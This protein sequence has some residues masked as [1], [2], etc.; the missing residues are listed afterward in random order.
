MNVSGQPATPASSI[1]VGAGGSVTINNIGG[2]RGSKRMKGKGR[3]SASNDSAVSNTRGT[4]R[5]DLNQR[6]SRASGS[7]GNV[8]G[9]GGCDGRSPAA[10][11]PLYGDGS[12]AA[13][14]TGNKGSDAMSAAAKPEFMTQLTKLAESIKSFISAFGSKNNQATESQAADATAPTS[15]LDLPEASK[16]TDAAANK[17]GCSGPSCATPANATPASTELETAT[18][19]SA[20]AKTDDSADADSSAVKEDNTLNFLGKLFM[21]FAS[22]LMGNKGAGA[23][24][25]GGALGS[26]FGGATRA[27][28]AV[29]TTTKTTVEEQPA[30]PA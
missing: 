14:T 12:E 13:R 18:P 19:G 15:P 28:P 27:K 22:M 24:S 29:K 21:A 20:T 23:A 10:A 4:N 5:A 30:I 1:N 11:M 9:S 25:N 6:I 2:G 26:L 3:R 17:G 7:R 16:A 8:C